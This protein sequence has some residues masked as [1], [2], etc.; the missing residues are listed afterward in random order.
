VSSTYDPSPGLILSIFWYYVHR[1]PLCQPQYRVSIYNPRCSRPVLQDI[2]LT[3]IDAAFFDRGV[4]EFRFGFYIPCRIF[5][6]I[7]MSHPI[8][9][10]RAKRLNVQPL[11]LLLAKSL[12]PLIGIINPVVWLSCFPGYVS[13]GLI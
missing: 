9:L 11:S 4:V 6:P 13:P 5:C 2:F 10:N 7:F 8:P 12:C 1:W 3:W